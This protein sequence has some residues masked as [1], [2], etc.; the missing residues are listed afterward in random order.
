MSDIL[1]VNNPTAGFDNASRTHPVSVNDTNV[2]N[3]VDMTKVTRSDGKSGNAEKELG[4]N[5]GSNFGTFLEA[6][7]NTPN[8]TE[9]LSD[10]L[11]QMSGETQQV[12]QSGFMSEL[13]NILK[14]MNLTQDELLSFI[15]EQ[16][17]AAGKFNNV[18]FQAVEKLLENT[19]SADLQME[20]LNFVKIYNDAS[21]SQSTLKNIQSILKNI[22]TY[23]TS[24]Y[25]Q[26]LQNIMDKL[27]ELNQN[28][29]EGSQSDITS[30]LKKEVVP[31][32]SNYIKNT[33]NMGKVRD[34]I[35]MLTLSIAKYENGS[36]DKL[37]QSFNRLMDFRDFNNVFNGITV[38]DLK[39]LI[40]NEN[41]NETDFSKYF[42][43][44]LKRGLKGEGG[45]ETKSAF[46]NIL[47]SL[48]LN[49][50]VYMPLNHIMVPAYIDGRPMFSEIWVDPK[51]KEKN[52]KGVKEDCKRLLVK[53]DIKDLGLFD[54]IITQKKNGVDL[55]LYYPEAL[56]Q[57]EDGIKKD[58]AGIMEKNGLNLRNFALGMSSKSKTIEE[59]FPQIYERIN[60]IDV[61]I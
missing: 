17:S 31:F 5:Y 10:I 14:G 40:Q 51:H 45:W 39:K 50:S 8:I 25:R 53:F 1:K 12:S 6:L 54:L 4:L 32:L 11:F 15:K 42:T 29:S 19:K 57:R 2:Q 9:I 49:E 34:F 20:M 52:E 48:L 59:V 58:I 3:I 16:S 43:D 61:K 41:T 33:N 21:S 24:N 60:M 30:F 28:R 36:M 26:P 13:T 38:D 47:Q 35:A 22:S 44:A 23:M 27:T 55:Q 7:R 18:F 46:Q 56:K 37:G